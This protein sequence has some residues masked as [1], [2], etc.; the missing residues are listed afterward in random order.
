MSVAGRILEISISCVRIFGP[1][2]CIEIHIGEALWQVS[3]RRF[4]IL[5]CRTSTG[6]ADLKRL[7][8]KAAFCVEH[9]LMCA[10]V[11]WLAGSGGDLHH[12][13]ATQESG[14]EKSA[15]EGN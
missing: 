8:G 3:A 5:F 1:F 10:I 6:R 2:L 15:A 11:A 14:L 13:G 4:A 7:R 12:I 9:H